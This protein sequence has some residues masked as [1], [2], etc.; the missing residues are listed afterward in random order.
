MVEVEIK[1][2]S[3]LVQVPSWYVL[4]LCLSKVYK[5]SEAIKVVSSKWLVEEVL[6]L[7][8]INL[9][10]GGRLDSLEEHVGLREV[11]HVGCLRKLQSISWIISFN[12]ILFHL[13]SHKF[14]LLEHW[15][16]ISWSIWGLQKLANLHAK[17]VVEVFDILWFG[18]KFVEL[19]CNFK[20]CLHLLRW[21]TYQFN[22]LLW[23]DIAAE[24]LS[25]L[26]GSCEVY[27]LGSLELLESVLST[28]DLLS[29]PTLN[30]LVD[31]NLILCSQ[32]VL[33]NFVVGLVHLSKLLLMW[34][35][36]L[37]CC[38]LNNLRGRN[39][40]TNLFLKGVL[41]VCHYFL[42]GWLGLHNLRK[43]ER[44]KRHCH[45]FK[46]HIFCKFGL[47]LIGFKLV[48][49]SVLIKRILCS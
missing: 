22:F 29:I 34:R 13:F 23:N 26:V 21:L 40:L 33:S 27:L 24:S 8:G 48:E 9:G 45:A 4:L 37:G 25:N 41:R 5:E 36:V 19:S 17:L 35:Q 20:S 11:L 31:Q 44:L 1:A 15:C 14:N 16:L 12:L 2:W 10:W 32:E 18:V 6:E 47:S 30:L 28:K 38:C 42:I 46:S 39:S 3:K 43:V 49:D 7:C